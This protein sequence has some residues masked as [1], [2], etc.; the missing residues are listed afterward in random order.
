MARIPYT[1]QRRG[2]E[3]ARLL[4]WSM[5]AYLMVANVLLALILLPFFEAI[6]RRFRKKRA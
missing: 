2:A 1:S 6:E 4:L 5:F 3:V